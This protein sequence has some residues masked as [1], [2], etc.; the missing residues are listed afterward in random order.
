MLPDPDINPEFYDGVPTK[1]LLAWVTDV[2]IIS[3]LTALAV[4]LTAFTGLFFLPF[5]FIVI[6]FAYRIITLTRGSATWGMRLFALELRQ[7]DDRPFDLP[8]AFFHT[9]GYSISW[10][11]PLIQIASAVLM[12]TTDRRQ[13]VSDLV[14]GSVALNRRG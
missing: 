10:S 9:L 4:P 14:L 2:L 11:I 1:R 13:G 6:S 3:V 5:L 8:T 7:A 12:C